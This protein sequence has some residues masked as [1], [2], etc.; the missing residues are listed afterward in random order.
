MDA[1]A[2]GA[3][4]VAAVRSVLEQEVD[5][6][7]ARIDALEKQ[8]AAMPIPKDG[9][10]GKSVTLEDIAP[11]IT[12]EVE[13]AVSAIPMPK[14]GENG[15]DGQ[16]GA[17]FTAEDA[18]PII[19]EEVA[20]A[21]AN[22]RQPEDGRDGKD[23]KDVDP[24][25]VKAMIADAVAALPPAEKGK[26]ADP[27]ETAALVR[28]EVARAV[29]ALPVPKDGISITVDDVRPLIEAEVS[30]AVTL[31]PIPKDGIDAMDVMIDR[32]GNLVFTMSDGRLKNV[33]LVVGKDGEPGR[34][35]APA[36]NGEPG[37]DG[38]DG[39]DAEIYAPDDVADNILTAVKMLSVV[40]NTK[41]VS[42]PSSLNINLPPLEL[43]MPDVAVKVVVPEQ[44]AP[45]VT[46]EPTTINVDAP[47]VNVST[48]EPK[49][50][51]T[52]TVVT[53]H[54]EKGRIKTFTQKE[55]EA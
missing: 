8:L 49:P 12:S 11:L 29:A 5:P 3:D 46:V 33:G 27:E 10:D 2:F 18:A 1:A 13:K 24:E 9:V 41:D 38:R 43:K 42:Q 14:D 37:K 36:K 15:A 16:D 44:K 22:I 23:G 26:D 25:L 53:S 55:V 47:V 51:R 7:L 54:D 19:A 45:V 48:P 39:R 17:S 21:F 20:K 28:E 30:K 31:I 34:D 50:K 40:P 32:E 6:L 52:E 4:V 35:A